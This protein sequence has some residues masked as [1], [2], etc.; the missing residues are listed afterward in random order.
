VIDLRIKRRARERLIAIGVILTVASLLVSLNRGA[1]AQSF[2]EYERYVHNYLNSGVLGNW[3]Y[4]EKPVF[5]VLFNESQ[6]LVG[7]NWSIVCPLVANH[8]YH[9]YCYGEWVNKSSEPKTDYDIY[10]YNPLG[11]LEG[12]HTE[13]AGLPEHL[14]TNVDDAFFVP[15]YSGNYTFVLVNDERESKGAEQATFMIIENV[16]CN[17]WCRHFVEGKD[18]VDQPVFNTSWAFEFMTESSYVEVWVRVPDTLDMYEARLYLMTD[19]KVENETVLNGVPLAWEPGLFGEKNGTLG[20]Y[21][22]ESKEYRGVAYASCEFPGQDMFLN[23]TMPHSGMNLYHLVLIGEAGAGTVEF[24]VKTEFNNVCLEPLIAPAR[25]YPY[26][27]TVIAYSSNSTDLEKATLNYT[28]DGWGNVTAVDMEIVDNKTCRAVVLGQAAGTVVSY[29]VEAVDVLLNTLN[30]S[31]SFSVKDAS[32]LNITVAAEKMYLGDNIVVRGYLAPEAEGKLVTVQFDSTNVTRT[33][34]CYTLENGTFTVV[35]QPN[36]T[37]VW[38]VQARFNGDNY[39]Y[40]SLS[41]QLLIKVDEPPL[42]LKYAPYIG[43]VGVIAVIGIV[44]YLKKS[45]A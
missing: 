14:G 12:Y 1:K 26:D 33:L 36:A 5:P 11:E 37:G 17:A 39:V 24:L 13:S 25:A 21:N 18:L 8:S 45:K 7:Q 4:V 3:T 35:F 32:S 29:R 23:Y 30:V 34:T 44:V 16:A 9:V 15:K 22:L 10:V 27:D 20:G 2:P 38:G 42:Y 6:V 41:S 31:G 43:L 40:E 19:S 28:T